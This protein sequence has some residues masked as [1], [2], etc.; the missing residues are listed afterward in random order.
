MQSK[1][2]TAI[3][4]LKDNHS[5]L[6]GDLQLNINGLGDIEITG[7]SQNTNFQNLTKKSC[8]Q[9]LIEI[10]QLFFEMLNASSELKEFIMGRAMK[11]NLWF[12]DYGKAS[13]AI[14]S[15]KNEV[16]EWQ[17]SLKK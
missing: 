17:L 2:K 3:E 5:F 14:C 13:I 10:K 1:I 15:E 8:L 4:F 7:W 12:D 16:I 6:V 11:F 9:E